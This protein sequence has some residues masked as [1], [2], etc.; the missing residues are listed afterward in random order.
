VT[1]FTSRMFLLSWKT[2][3]IYKRKYHLNPRFDPGTMACGWA[4]STTNDCP[5]KLPPRDSRWPCDAKHQGHAFRGMQQ[6]HQ[7]NHNL[8]TRKQFSVL[9]LW[10]NRHTIAKDVK[11][12]LRVTFWTS[13][14]RNPVR[15]VV[16]WNSTS[17]AQQAV[18]NAVR[19]N[20]Q[21]APQTLL[22]G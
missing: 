9:Q 20:H 21:G 15:H 8:H 4:F 14:V 6:Q 3:R 11:E 17:Y 12:H 18:A 10:D 22:V 19:Q 16:N 7:A 13:D 2:M 1:R 5:M